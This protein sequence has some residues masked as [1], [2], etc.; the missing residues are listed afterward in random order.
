MGDQV[1]QFGDASLMDAEAP[2]GGEL[3]RIAAMLPAR[4]GLP[5]PMLLLRQGRQMTITLTPQKWDGRGL[6]G[7][8]LRPL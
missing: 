7:C 1:V 4:E 6:L 8:H 5:T 2:A 3:Q